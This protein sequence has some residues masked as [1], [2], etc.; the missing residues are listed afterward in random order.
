MTGVR[1]AGCK[2]SESARKKFNGTFSFLAEFE[3]PKLSKQVYISSKIK[4]DL[5]KLPNFW[6]RI[7]CR[8][9]G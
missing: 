8:Q 1:L 7:E 4:E 6:R 2:W 3:Y 9:P 5:A